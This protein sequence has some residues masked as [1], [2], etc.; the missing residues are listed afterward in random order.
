MLYTAFYYE[1][2]IP[3]F[4]RLKK[5]KLYSEIFYYFMAKISTDIT[6]FVFFVAFRT[7]AA[8]LGKVRLFLQ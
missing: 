4:L 5:K 3:F 2:H 6:P 8:S 1:R 7:S